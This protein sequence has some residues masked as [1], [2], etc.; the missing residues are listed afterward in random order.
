VRPTIDVTKKWRYVCR[1]F[2]TKSLKEGAIWRI[3]PLL[4]GDCKQRSLLRSSR[5]ITHATVEERCFLC[6]PYRDVISKGQSQSLISSVWESAVKRGIKP[7]A[8]E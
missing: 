4:S 6:G 5:N 2:G 7:E 8:E 1:L 3:D